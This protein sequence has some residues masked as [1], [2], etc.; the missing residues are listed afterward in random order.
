[1]PRAPSL[2]LPTADLPALRKRVRALAE[3]RPAV[4]RMVDPLGRVI[5]V[6]K[7][8]RLR[9]RLLSYFNADYPEDKAGRILH[10]AKDIQWEYVPSEFAAYLGELRRIQQ[11]RPPFNLRMNRV[12]RACF[13]QVSGGQAPRLTVERKSP[14]PEA[15]CYG[16]FASTA[17]VMD[18]IRVLNDVLGLR[19]CA[20]R[21][22]MVFPGQGDLF[23]APHRAACMRHDFGFC[24]GPCAG[25][26]GEPE[27]H[28]RAE[29]AVAFLE[30]RTVAPIGRVIEA[31]TAAAAAQQ[32][33]QAAKW[34]ER[35]EHLEW[36]LA[37][38]S[39]ARLAV[40]GLTF[41]YRDPGLFGDDRAYL[42]RHGVVQASYPFPTT[43]I[44]REA[45]QA[46]VSDE[47]ARP[48]SPHAGLPHQHLDEILLLMAWFRKHPDAFRRTS[49]LEEW[50]KPAA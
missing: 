23:Q 20:E 34:R 19:D 32:F 4:Y 11:H 29:T 39:R 38:T 41:V 31:M 33:E 21:M 7:A 37:A 6:G 10:A 26:I 3:N 12:R 36:L 9:A 48:A 18:A 27:Y 42:V 1:M 40:E 43:P 35:F 24:A 17:R 16:P 15:R 5:Y 22:P 47:L 2:P 14:N 45:F 28:A 13:V 50:A 30:G 25:F 46:V 49:R 8:K 44:E